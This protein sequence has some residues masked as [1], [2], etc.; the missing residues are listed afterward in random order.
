LTTGSEIPRSCK[1]GVK[2]LL[3][4]LSKKAVKISL[5]KSIHRNA[6]DVSNKGI[7]KEYAKHLTSILSKL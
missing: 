2:E 4:R 5:I 3:I 1:N 6:E 7:I